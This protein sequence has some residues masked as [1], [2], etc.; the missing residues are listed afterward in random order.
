[1]D[2]LYVFSVYFVIYII[3]AYLTSILLVA[4]FILQYFLHFP[5]CVVRDPIR[6][7][8]QRRFLVLWVLKACD[9]LSHTILFWA[10]DIR[11]FPLS[12]KNV[13]F[14]TMR[15]IILTFPQSQKTCRSRTAIY[16]PLTGRKREGR[17]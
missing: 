10:T 14:L 13:T 7:S 15:V 6:P 3:M 9:S 16:Q 17:G 1:V 4:K 5:C 12:C 2:V 8:F 11:I